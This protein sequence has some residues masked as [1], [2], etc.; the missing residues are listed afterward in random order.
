MHNELNKK[1]GIWGGINNL[2]FWKMILTVGSMMNSGD[3]KKDMTYE[4]DDETKFTFRRML[5]TDPE[6]WDTLIGYNEFANNHVIYDS[7]THT[8]TLKNI[9][10]IGEWMAYHFDGYNFYRCINLHEK[11]KHIIMNNVLLPGNRIPASAFK[12][13]SLE[14]IVL[15]EGIKAIGGDVNR[16]DGTTTEYLINNASDVISELCVFDMCA[17]LVSI[18]I[19]KSVEVIGYD[20]F[21]FC[22]SLTSI[23]I[24]G[25]RNPFT[26]IYMSSFPTEMKY[27]ITTGNVMKNLIDKDVL[28][29]TEFNL[30]NLEGNTYHIFTV[31]GSVN[32]ARYL[33]EI[34]ESPITVIAIP[35][36]IK[37]YVINPG[38]I[39]DLTPHKLYT[40]T[41]S[42]VS[43]AENS[44]VISIT[45]SETY[46]PTPTT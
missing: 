12:C 32:I 5:E 43:Q 18:T 7:S 21:A 37:S 35:E 42:T 17:S 14:S 13:T 11:I 4:S 24:Q 27:I 16:Y 33:S 26:S 34:D 9:K 46:S 40:F 25:N 23:F 31:Y 45:D 36:T 44:S 20:A 39:A 19:P 15:P 38:D 29:N 41:L 8:L 22:S 28:F 1:K 10:V 3:G 6:T 30:D 2:D